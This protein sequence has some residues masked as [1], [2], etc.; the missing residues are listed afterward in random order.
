[1][2]LIPE[3]PSDSPKSHSKWET[4]DWILAAWIQS[5]M[6]YHCTRLFLPVPPEQLETQRWLLRGRHGYEKPTEGK[7]HSSLIEQ[8]G[9]KMYFRASGKLIGSSMT[10]CNQL[11]AWER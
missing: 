11:S 4:W 3:R 5:L 6:I 9:R 10:C 1:M 8:H 7:M 2:R